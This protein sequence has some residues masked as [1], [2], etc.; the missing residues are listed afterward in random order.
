MTIT[1]SLKNGR[2]VLKLNG[3]FDFHA[4]HAFQTA[5][6]KVAKGEERQVILRFDEVPY[7]DSAALGMLALMHKQL[8]A[9]HIQ[10]TIVNPQDFVK[11]IL[12]LAKMD[13]FFPIHTTEELAT[14]S[15]AR[16]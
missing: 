6:E 10:A 11:G 8:T 16:I 12:E 1:E 9:Q 14:S 5:I 2:K 13:L 15:M 3:R 7:I 4:R